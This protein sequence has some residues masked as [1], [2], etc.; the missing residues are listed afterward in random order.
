VKKR[1]S[2]FIGNFQY[3]N[4][5]TTLMHDVDVE[6]KIQTLTIQHTQAPSFVKTQ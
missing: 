4:K 5:D 2:L 3:T 6:F 1:D